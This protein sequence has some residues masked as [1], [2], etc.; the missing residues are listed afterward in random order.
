[1][2]LFQ[3]PDRRR[4]R[5]IGD[6]SVRRLVLIIAVLVAAGCGDDGGAK[7]TEGAP[8]GPPDTT[9]G[10]ST[11]SPSTTMPGTTG[12][13]PAESCCEADGDSI[14]CSTC[15]DNA[16]SCSARRTFGETPLAEDFT[17]Q[18][19]CVAA[20]TVGL[21]C[22]DDSSCCD[23]DATCDA[24][25]FCRLPVVPTTSGG[26]DGSGGTSNSSTGDDDTTTSGAGSESTSTT[27]SG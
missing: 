20:G 27:T 4:R 16:A 3:R 5:W 12:T 13:E 11:G 26:S 7:E 8:P 14:S 25:G 19:T 18:T 22:A 6:V 1:M 23:A 15:S 24:E 21:W 2:R 17:C 10:T 9:A